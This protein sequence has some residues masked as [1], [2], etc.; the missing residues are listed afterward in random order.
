[1]E[2]S[3]TFIIGNVFFG[4]GRFNLD[5]CSIFCKS[6]HRLYDSLI[7]SHFFDYVN[8]VEFISATLKNNNKKNDCPFR[9]SLHSISADTIVCDDAEYIILKVFV[10]VS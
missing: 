1:M 5:N 6:V 10:R 8:A 7:G 9:F 2:T 4:F 3:S